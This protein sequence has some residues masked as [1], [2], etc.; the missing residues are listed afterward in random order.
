M[1]LKPS[2][3]ILPYS[4]TPFRLSIRRSDQR[5]VERTGWTQTYFILDVLKNFLKTLAGT[6]PEQIDF[7]QRI[8]FLEHVHELFALGDGD[9]PIPGH[10]PF[11]VARYFINSLAAAMTLSTDGKNGRSSQ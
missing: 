2:T 5:F 11:S 4:I 9:R 8:L 1:G 10:T 7:D 3:P 6:G